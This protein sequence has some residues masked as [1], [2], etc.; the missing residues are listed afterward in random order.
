MKKEN[1]VNE[2][3]KAMPYDAL[4]CGVISFEE[5]ITKHHADPDNMTMMD[6]FGKDKSLRVGYESEQIVKLAERYAEYRVIQY[7]KQKLIERGLNAT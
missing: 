7:Q 1:T 6:N 2:P 3:T 4:L 5:Y